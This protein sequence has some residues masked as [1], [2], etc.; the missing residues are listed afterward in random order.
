MQQT[1]VPDDLHRVLMAAFYKTADWMRN[2][3]TPPAIPA[4]NPKEAS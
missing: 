2:T 1:G 3:P 4:T